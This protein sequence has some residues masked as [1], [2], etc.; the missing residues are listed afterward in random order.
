VRS[1]PD[2][3]FGRARCLLDTQHCHASSSTSHTQVL[4]R[5]HLEMAAA[6]LLRGFVQAVYA[7]TGAVLAQEMAAVRLKAAGGVQRGTGPPLAEV[8]VPY[9]EE[10]VG[11]VRCQLRARNVCIILCCGL[12]WAGA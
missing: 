2:T 1:S 3:F 7:Y 8:R 6:P 4:S 9:L 5:Q 12:G 11:K 10:Q